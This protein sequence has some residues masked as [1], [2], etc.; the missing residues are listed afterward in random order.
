MNHPSDPG[1]A[2][3][4]GITRDVLANWRGQ[5]V[6]VNDV[7]NMSIDEARRIF[8]ARYWTPM[9]M[10]EVDFPAALMT[11]NCGVN[12]G[13]VRGCKNTPK[14]ALNQQ[15]SNLVVDGKIGPK[16]LAAAE[17]ADLATLV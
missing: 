2:T 7:K 8:Y 17:A 16:T 10:D 13:I 12:S 6:T 4:F 15:S 3:N 14:K 1:G 9:R 11:Y 5:P